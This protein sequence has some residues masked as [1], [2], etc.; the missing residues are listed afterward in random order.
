[1][2]TFIMTAC[3]ARPKP[4]DVSTA[5]E[6]EPVKSA[7]GDSWARVDF[8]DGVSLALPANCTV[9]EGEVAF[10]HGG[11]R[12]QCGGVTAEITWGMWGADSF[13]QNGGQCHTT[14]GGVPVLMTRNAGST[15]VQAWYQ[16]HQQP[17]EP[18][19]SAWSSSEGDRAVIESIVYSGV[20]KPVRPHQR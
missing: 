20:L 17:Y 5:P 10:M 14:I 4:A 2:A 1:M 19:I 13:G 12:W 15:S 7:R 18:V 11:K 6:C 16:T 3:G 8:E 9:S